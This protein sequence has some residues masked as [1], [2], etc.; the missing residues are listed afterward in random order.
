[1]HQ[2]PQLPFTELRQAIIAA[3]SRNRRVVALFGRPA[4]GAIELFA[5]LACDN[6]GL[7][8][9]ARAVVEGNT[10]PSMTPECPQVHL[11][12]REL[13]EQWGLIPEGHPWWKPVRFHDAYRPG[14][15]AFGRAD[16]EP[17]VV[18]VTD[19]YRVE[20]EEDSRGGRG[21]RPR[22]CHRARPLPLPVPRRT[23]L[24]PGD[25]PRLPTPRHREDPGRR[26]RQTHHPS[27]GNPGRRHHG[28]ARQ[29]LLP[30]PG[31]PVR[32]PPPA[33]AL[34]LRGVALE[35]ERLA[36]HTGDLGALAGDIGYLPTASFCGRLRGDF[37]N[38]TALLCG[39]RFGR[40]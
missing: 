27:H 29:R 7:L 8:E 38:I 32:V 24:P 28:G 34:A 3:P 15:D 14:P 4:G 11:F 23:R 30:G 1:M 17:R 25:L 13:G 19:F 6:D 12:E 22:G 16:G 33:R 36:N 18:G 40:G 35:L 2:I 5:V 21:P 20:G 26:P 31:R 39:N 9:V 37:L 10:F